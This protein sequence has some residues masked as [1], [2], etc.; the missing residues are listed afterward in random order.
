MNE[1][2]A[3][4]GGKDQD[5]LLKLTHTINGVRNTSKNIISLH[6]GQRK[7]LKIDCLAAEFLTKDA[8]KKYGAWNIF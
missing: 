6:V 5:K 7:D 8:V 4:K 2:K 1:S 3:R